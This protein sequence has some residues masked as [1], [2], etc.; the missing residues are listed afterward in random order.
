[1]DNQK[2]RL[3]SVSDLT[4]DAPLSKIEDDRRSAAVLLCRTLALGILRKRY[5]EAIESGT[6][7]LSERRAIMKLLLEWTDSETVN[8]AGGDDVIE[9]AIQRAQQG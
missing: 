1:M 8:H 3:S 6:C 9:L 5:P 4:S 7:G 2:P